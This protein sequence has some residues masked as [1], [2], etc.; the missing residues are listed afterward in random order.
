MISDKTV[1]KLHIVH[2]ELLILRSYFYGNHEVF[3][4]LSFYNK[5]YPDK[6]PIRAMFQRLEKA[7]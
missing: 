5:E 3:R 7:V 1:M 4:H 6:T 2:L